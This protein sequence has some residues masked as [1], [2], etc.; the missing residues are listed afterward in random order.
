MLMTAPDT[1]GCRKCGAQIRAGERI[2]WENGP[3]HVGCSPIPD[4]IAAAHREVI[5][6]A[7]Q[8]SQARDHSVTPLVPPDYA[9]LM[10]ATVIAAILLFGAVVLQSVHG[11]HTLVRLVVCALSAFMG[12]RLFKTGRPVLAVLLGFAALL[13]NP[14]LQIQ[15][16]RNL[17]QTI[18]VTTIPLLAFV[19]FLLRPKKRT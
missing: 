17:W 1:C 11:Y 2:S 15:L 16:P 6:A 14:I 19:L 4:D 13:Y 10:T 12:F 8:A 3:Y 18:D 7:R 9:A 5:E